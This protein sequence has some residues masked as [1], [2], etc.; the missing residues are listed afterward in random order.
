MKKTNELVELC[1]QIKEELKKKGR[2][3][4]YLYLNDL[5]DD[6][7]DEDEMYE[8][9][10]GDYYETGADCDTRIA[11]AECGG[12]SDEYQLDGLYIDEDD[13]LMFYTSEWNEDENGRECGDS[14]EEDLDDVLNGT[15]SE[16]GFWLD[17]VLEYCL[18]YIKSLENK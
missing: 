11:S 18:N 14:Y 4:L 15:W 13:T 8:F 10:E 6:K 1:D 17:N 12:Y 9:D 7:M 2:D 16:D 3:H 5:I